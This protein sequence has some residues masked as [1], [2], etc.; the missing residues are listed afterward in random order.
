M[1]GIGV[2]PWM[3]DHQ[4]LETRQL[5]RCLQDFDFAIFCLDSCESPGCGKNQFGS[6]S[7]PRSGP[8]Y[9]SVITVRRR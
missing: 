3:P 9:G 4:V 5:T 8:K 1:R 7:A 6:W 2:H